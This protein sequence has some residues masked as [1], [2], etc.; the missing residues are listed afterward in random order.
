VNNPDRI[1]GFQAGLFEK[2]VQFDPG[3]V[4]AQPR[5]FST[6]TPTEIG[7]FGEEVVGR[8]L[9][10]PDPPTALFAFDDHRALPVIRAIERRGGR[11]GRDLCVVG[12]GDSAIRRGVCDWLTSCRIYPRQM[13]REALKA[14]LAGGERREGR[15]IIVPDRLYVR[16]S[17]C[18][19]GHSQWRPGSCAPVR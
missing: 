17:S 19:P 13:G 18:P 12:Y 7:S 11:A 9:G 4:V 5:P 15:I 8:L 14:A 3:L 10:L 2:G 1:A 16:G 6:M